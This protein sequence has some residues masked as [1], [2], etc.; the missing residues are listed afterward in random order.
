MSLAAFALA[1]AVSGAPTT[2]KDCP[3]CV[4]MTVVP[5]GSFMMGSD[6]GEPGRSEGPIHRVTIRKPFAMGTYEVTQGEFDR[7]VRET[8]HQVE[9]GCD[10]WPVGA[11]PREASNWRD[12]GYGR[13]PRD[14]D[15]VVCVSWRDARAFVDWMARTTG[16]PYRL[17][18]EA[19]WEYAARAGT[20]ADF[21]WG[22]DPEDGC[23]RYN[24]YDSSSEPRFTWAASKCSDGEPLVS[25]AGSYPPNAFG[26]YDMIGNV[27]EWNQDCHVVPYPADHVDERAVEPPPGAVCERRDVRG[28]S[29]ATRPDRNRIAFRGRD[30]ETTRYFMFGFRVA[31]DLTP[32]EAR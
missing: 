6:K 27:W 14:R 13:T 20:T 5:A 10:V 8:G 31:R 22:D 7:F 25:L 32:A 2:F 16:K 28:G 19:E 12:P 15:P 30:P 26:L 24:G 29:W 17:P 3:D 1:L 4:A 18:S 11:R 21:T 23:T 9:P